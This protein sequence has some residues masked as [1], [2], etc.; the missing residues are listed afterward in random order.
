MTTNPKGRQ[1]ERISI[2]NLQILLLKMEWKKV[3]KNQDVL[4]LCV[5]GFNQLVQKIVLMTFL[6]DKGIRLRV[7]SLVVV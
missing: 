5:C 6:K 1:E 2:I 7:G 3:S 4:K